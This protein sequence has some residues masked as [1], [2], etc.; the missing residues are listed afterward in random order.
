MQVVKGRSVEPLLPGG[1]DKGGSVFSEE[2]LELAP[3][4]KFLATGSE[5]PLEN[6]Y[7]FHC[8]LCRQN[9]S[10]RTR[11]LYELKRPF[12]RDCHFR[13]QQRLREKICPGKVRGRDKRVL[14]GSGLEAERD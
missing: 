3:F 13:A 6:K 9:I 4:T 8:L 12:Q 1:D 5:D 2:V 10:M 14:Y 11:G 7:C